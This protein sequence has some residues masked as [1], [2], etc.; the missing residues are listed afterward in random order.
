MKQIEEDFIEV[1][2]SLWVTKS[3]DDSLDLRNQQKIIKSNF[4]VCKRL[5]SEHIFRSTT[6]RL[7]NQM[8]YIM[9]VNMLD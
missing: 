7:K 8:E 4:K 9:I 6:L 2:K 5:E 3:K 1:R